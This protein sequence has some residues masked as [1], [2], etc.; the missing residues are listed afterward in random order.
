[1]TTVIFP[2]KPATTIPL[3]PTGRTFTTRRSSRIATVPIGYADGYSRLLSN[4]S[5][6][7]INGQYAPVV[8]NICMDQMMVDITDISGEVKA[9]DEV[10]LIGRQGD[11]EITAEEIA[12]LMGTIPYE[13]LCIIGKRVPRVYIRNGSVVNV[14]NYLL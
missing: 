6:V 7:L 5:R 2:F 12:G 13:I 3:T 10:V 11:N 8:G 4:K 1:M 14:L 9:G